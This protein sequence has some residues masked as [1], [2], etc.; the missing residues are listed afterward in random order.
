MSAWPLARF[1]LRS[2]SPLFE[3]DLAALAAGRRE[4]IELALRWFYESNRR[5][6]VDALLSAWIA[7][8]AVAMD[9][10][11]HIQPLKDLLA[12]AYGTTSGDVA[13]RL[14]LGRLSSI[15][16]GIVHRGSRHSLA[17][18]LVDYVQALFVDVLDVALNRP[19]RMLAGARSE[20][21][22]EVVSATL[23]AMEANG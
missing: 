11:G 3:T 12:A 5:Y 7:I 17:P 9:G 4:R 22:R 14:H 10:D 13:A 23:A 20:Q 19:C 15:R 8:E 16:A 2:S 1:A 6:A 18:L 21:V